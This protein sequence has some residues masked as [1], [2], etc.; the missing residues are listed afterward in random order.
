MKFHNV[1]KMLRQKILVTRQTES[2]FFGFFFD[3]LR[4]EKS[5]FSKHLWMLVKFH[6]KL[7]PQRI[8]I[9]EMRAK[10]V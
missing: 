1:H 8:K 9:V 10:S 4:H 2:S 5:I 7:E 6:V 3:S